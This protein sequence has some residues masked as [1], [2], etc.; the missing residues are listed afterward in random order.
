MIQR[1]VQRGDHGAYMAARVSPDLLL[2]LCE[3]CYFC[4]CEMDPISTIFYQIRWILYLFTFLCV[5]AGLC[6]PAQSQP[7]IVDFKR[8]AIKGLS[9]L[10]KWSITVWVCC[11]PETSFSKGAF[12]W[13][14]IKCFIS[15]GLVC[16]GRWDDSMQMSHQINTLRCLKMEVMVILWSEERIPAKP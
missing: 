13:S 2:N 16:L 10:W 4:C 3:T 11:V 8:H 1:S 15:A 14:T 6:I 5:C 9:F 7:E 12:S